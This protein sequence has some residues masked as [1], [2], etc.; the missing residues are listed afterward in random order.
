MKK[1][2]LLALLVVTQVL[3]D[4]WLSRGMKSFGTITA[5]DPALLL[6]LIVFLF[7][8]PWIWLGIAFL[9]SS[10]GF[11]LIAISR[12]DL[13]YVLPI[14]ASSY[15]LNAVL[16]S[17]IL[18]EQV[19]LH[20]WMSTALIAF[21]VLLVSL[22]GKYSS[23]AAKNAATKNKDAA[24]E[25]LPALLFP[26]GIYL[27]RTWIAVIILSLA[28]AA[29]DLF[30]AMGMKRLGEVRTQ[31]LRSVSSIL[32]L[33]RRILTNPIILSG[34]CCQTIAFISFTLVLSWAD[35]SFVRPATSLAYVF[36]LLGAYYVLK[37]Q[38]VLQRLIGITLIGVGVA[39]H[40]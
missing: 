23:T 28:D 33:I 24:K 8:N 14:H 40:R 38:V 20:R 10:L 5:F 9:L 27:S 2:I 37:E 16:A 26:L 15:V 7:T 21:G 4:I 1:F 12:M 35:I 13:S 18:G 6:H 3:G 25:M 30:L 29:G 17:L 11:Y 32:N 31:Q 19:T 36:S 22:S 34:I 39:L